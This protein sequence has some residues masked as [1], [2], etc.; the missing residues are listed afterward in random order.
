MRADLPD[1][2]IVTGGASGIGEAVV[3]AFAD[4]GD[5]D[6]G[7]RADSI[8]GLKVAIRCQSGRTRPRRMSC[9]DGASALPPSPR[10]Q[11]PGDGR[12]HAG[13]WGM[14]ECELLPANRPLVPVPAPSRLCLSPA[15][16]ICV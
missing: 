6:D 16:G 1:R 13:F 2:V 15:T 5:Q 8:D 14:P 12:C 9:A 4:N 7:R 11:E 3:R 10:R